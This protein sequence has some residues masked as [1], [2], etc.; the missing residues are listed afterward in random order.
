MR[1]LEWTIWCLSGLLL[2]SSATLAQDRAAGRHAVD[3]RQT[4]RVTS[5]DC[6]TDPTGDHE[7]QT[8]VHKP[9]L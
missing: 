8:A 1:T 3:P 5:P 4:I 2:L 7:R 9:T 6:R